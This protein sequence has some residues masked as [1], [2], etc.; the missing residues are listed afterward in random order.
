MSDTP[1]HD[2]ADEAYNEGYWRFI[3][4]QDDAYRATLTPEQLRATASTAARS[5]TAPAVGPRTS[6]SSTTSTRT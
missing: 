4:E 2:A 1:E 6:R 3:E 5:P